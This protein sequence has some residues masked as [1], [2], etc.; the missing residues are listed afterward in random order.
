MHSRY[1][2]FDLLFLPLLFLPIG[3][4]GPDGDTGVVGPV[5]ASAG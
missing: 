5:M 3:L 2:V 1:F 4:C